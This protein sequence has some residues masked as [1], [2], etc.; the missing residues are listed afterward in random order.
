[1]LAA[2]TPAQPRLAGLPN[3]VLVAA[4]ADG[5]TVLARNVRFCITRYRVMRALVRSIHVSIH[6]GVMVFRRPMGAEGPE[7]EK[8]GGAFRRMKEKT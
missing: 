4:A 3:D 7:H 5:Q 2:F 1:M 8:C 6:L